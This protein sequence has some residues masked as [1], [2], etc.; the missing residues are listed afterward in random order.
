MHDIQSHL[1]IDPKFWD[2]E[3]ILFPAD[4]DGSNIA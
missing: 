1:Q 2:F 4:S 3:R